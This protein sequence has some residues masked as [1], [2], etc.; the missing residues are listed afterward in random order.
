MTSARPATSNKGVE[1]NVLD[2]MAG[3]SSIWDPLF[4]PL[5][6]RAIKG[7][8][9]NVLAGQAVVERS[10]SPFRTIC[11]AVIGH[12]KDWAEGIISAVRIWR[13]FNHLVNDGPVH[14]AIARLEKIGS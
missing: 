13:H 6:S 5:P 2:V 12:L 8:W 3:P 9:R 14:P 7:A 11:K 10:R 4:A 1:E